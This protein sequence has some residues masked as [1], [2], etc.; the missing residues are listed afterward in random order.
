MKA[1]SIAQFLNQ[2]LGSAISIQE[3]DVSEY[4]GLGTDVE[5]NFHELGLQ[6]RIEAASI[7]VII[8]VCASFAIEPR[9]K[10]KQR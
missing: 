5:Q 3:D 10:K 8:K 6:A 9:S 1:L 2:K 7:T 4:T